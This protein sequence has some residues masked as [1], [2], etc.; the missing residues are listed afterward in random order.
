MFVL[1]NLCPTL[2][3]IQSLAGA[4][5]GG[6]MVALL[7]EGAECPRALVERMARARPELDCSVHELGVDEVG[8]TVR[9][10]GEVVR[11]EESAF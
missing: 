6:F 10:G 8:V 2:P 11:I 9:K 3:P 4:G 1:A 7:R 5:G